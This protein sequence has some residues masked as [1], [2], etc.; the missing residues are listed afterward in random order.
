MAGCLN[1]KPKNLPLHPIFHSL[2][3]CPRVSATVWRAGKQSG[4]VGTQ[5]RPSAFLVFW[6]QGHFSQQPR[7]RLQSGHDS[8]GGASFS[9]LGASPWQ[10]PP[11]HGG[12]SDAHTSGRGT[13][14]AVPSPSAGGWQQL[15][16]L[17]LYR[18]PMRI[19]SRAVPSNAG[20]HWFCRQPFHFADFESKVR[21]AMP[22]GSPQLSC[23]A[24]SVNVNRWWGVLQGTPTN[25]WSWQPRQPQPTC[26][27]T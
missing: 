18:L 21:A 9:G 2:L 5:F 24:L 3:K 13:Q 15:T 26:S 1:P 7:Q 6:L 17:G 11:R 14:L 25:M 10:L 27:T 4:S 16:W 22:C 20:N 12:G 23:P 19:A 8:Q